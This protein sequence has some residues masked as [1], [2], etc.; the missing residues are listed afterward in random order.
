MFEECSSLNLPGSTWMGPFRLRVVLLPQ[1]MAG[2]AA[3]SPPVSGRIGLMAT[4]APTLA[5]MPPEFAAAAPGLTVVPCLAE[6]ALAALDAGDADGHDRAA[7]R[8]AAA[9]ADCDVIALS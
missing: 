4:F 8:A 3:N 7:V 5:S 6:G 2:K 9:L 1:A